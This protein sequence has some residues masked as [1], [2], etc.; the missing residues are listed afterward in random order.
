MPITL[1]VRYSSTALTAVRRVAGKAA[2]AIAKL[3]IAIGT[4]YKGT[5]ICVARAMNQFA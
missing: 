1:Y 2:N 3:C 4:G 5:L